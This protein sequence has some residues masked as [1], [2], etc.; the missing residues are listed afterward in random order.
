MF[1]Y[2]HKCENED[3]LKRYLIA[4]DADVVNDASEATHILSDVWDKV[5]NFSEIS[6]LKKIIGIGCIKE[7]KQSVE[8]SGQC[9]GVGFY[10]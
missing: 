8:S 6:K 7:R 3:V 1:A 5:R 10:K 2:L 4:F 9:M